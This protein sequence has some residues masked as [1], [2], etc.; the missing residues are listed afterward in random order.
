[1]EVEGWIRIFI[2]TNAD[3]QHCFS[4]K[5]YYFSTKA[6]DIY[7]VILPQAIN[8]SEPCTL[9]ANGS[10]TGEQKICMVYNGFSDN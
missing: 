9:T 1:M 8:A 5:N 3:P 10:D 7:F 2:E 6:C 4:Q